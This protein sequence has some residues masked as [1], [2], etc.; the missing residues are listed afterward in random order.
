MVSWNGSSSLVTAPANTLHRWI[1]RVRHYSRLLPGRVSDCL[2]FSSFEVS[3][4]TSRVRP[5][6]V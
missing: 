4:F 1:I 2:A 3:A 5:P 6:I